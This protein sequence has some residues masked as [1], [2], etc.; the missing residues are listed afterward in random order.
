[1]K[2]NMTQATEA[3]NE[4]LG[5]VVSIN[6]HIPDDA[7][8]AELLGTERNGH[9]V[10]IRADGL[11]VTAGYIILDASTVW[12]GTGA[13]TVVPAYVIAND[14]ESGLGLL[15]PALPIDLP[16]MELDRAADL[17]IGEP[18]FAVGSGG[19]SDTI[20]AGVVAKREFAGRWEYL[21]DEAVYTSPAHTNWA[22]AA[23]LNG[24][25]RLCGIGSLLVQDPD[26]TDQ[27]A[28]V[29]MFIPI[30]T[31]APFIDELCEYGRRRSPARPWL[32]MLIHE[33]DEQLLVAGVYRGCPA[34]A[35]GLLP[36][37]VIVRVGGRPPHRLGDFLRRVWALGPAGVTVPLTVLR[38]GELVQA[39]IKTADRNAFIRKDTIN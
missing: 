20:E 35:A 14:F 17:S 8:S 3:M 7:M 27:E 5:A 16:A 1:M 21:L 39:A 12:V 15:K 31:L 18:V 9:G 10:V 11:I 19:I 13:D 22:G 36:G 4:I 32:G 30:E 29:N 24:S 38:D 6:A 26:V 25:G 37:D 34:D 33:E 2:E 23:L 28:P